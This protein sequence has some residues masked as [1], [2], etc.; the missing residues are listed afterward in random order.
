MA[1]NVENLYVE[2]DADNDDNEVDEEIEIKSQQPIN[3][4]DNDKDSNI[5]EH[6]EVDDEDE[7]EEEEE[8]E[9]EKQN[10]NQKKKTIDY[11]ALFSKFLKDEEEENKTTDSLINEL[12]MSNARVQ[13]AQGQLEFINKELPL[14]TD[15]IKKDILVAKKENLVL[16]L[17]KYMEDVQKIYDKINL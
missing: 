10:D 15:K 12:K 11:S 14:V 6:E 5:D 2:D 1:S 13:Y 8:E 4:K 9:K 7:N 16:D 3:K 17:V